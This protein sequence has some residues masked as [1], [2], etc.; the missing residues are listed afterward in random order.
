MLYLVL[1]GFEFLKKE[2]RSGVRIEHT[3]FANLTLMFFIIA[4]TY[5]V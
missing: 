1:V 3:S 5:Y 2:L 4:T